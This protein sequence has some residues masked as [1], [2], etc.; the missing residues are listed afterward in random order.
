MSLTSVGL[1]LKLPEE[2]R[3]TMKNQGAMPLRYFPRA[4]IKKG[5]VVVPPLI[6]DDPVALAPWVSVSIAGL[7]VD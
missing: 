7:V 2:A 6:A 4:P 1:G 3:A 5:Y